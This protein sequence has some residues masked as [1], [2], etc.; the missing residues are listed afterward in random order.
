[1]MDYLFGFFFL[2]VFVNN[3][4]EGMCFK[5]LYFYKFIIILECFYYLLVKSVI[6]NFIIIIIV[7]DFFIFII[8]FYIDICFKKIGSFLLFL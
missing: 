8:Y 7:F 4:E 2:F 3:F 1:M 6:R 5:F